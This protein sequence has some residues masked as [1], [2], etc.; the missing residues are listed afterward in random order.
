MN[1]KPTRRKTSSKRDKSAA[2]PEV[3]G[4]SAGSGEAVPNSPAAGGGATA[5]KP[6]SLPA[7][8]FAEDLLGK[9]KPLAGDADN[10]ERDGG[11][12]DG[13][14]RDKADTGKTA[15]EAALAAG[16]TTST[17]PERIFHFAENL[18]GA[19]AD[20]E[21]AAVRR[22]GTWVSFALAGETFALP[23]EPVREVVRV[24][25]ITRVPHAPKPI[26]GVTNLR[27]R[28]IPVIDLRLRID[29]SPTQFE[30][31]TRI[32]VVAAR[33]RLIGLLVD[34]VQ[35]VIHLDLDQIQP[36][37]GDV[38]TIQS[39]YISGVYHFDDRLVLLLNVERALVVQGTEEFIEA[40][41]KAK[42]AS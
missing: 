29:L 7:F 23:V 40:P 26:R 35:Q 16:G 36:P 3:E 10:G 20:H 8:G 15:D 30:R 31:T 13:G 11:E 21:I 5:K 17:D 33:G 6:T 4:S 41:G 19:R 24:S 1:K 2:S 38:M 9:S 18:D 37:P 27:G 28:V 25:S 32:I 42:S 22:M 34:A 12:R 39:D 14:E